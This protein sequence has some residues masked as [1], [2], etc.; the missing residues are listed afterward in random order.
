MGWDPGLVFKNSV[1]KGMG[2]DARLVLK[3][4]QGAIKIKMEESLSKANAGKTGPWVKREAEIPSP[5]G[6]IQYPNN[7]PAALTRFIGRE[8]DI[9]QIMKWLTDYRLVTLTGPGGCG[10]TRLAAQIASN[11]LPLYAH[12]VWLVEFAPLSDP[13]SIPQAVAAVLGVREYPGVELQQAVLE[14]LSVRHMLS[15]EE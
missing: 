9:A 4:A 1:R 5:V 7:L 10:K 3:N 13:A 2:L 14:Y 15:N 8:R 12:G 6:P 11:F